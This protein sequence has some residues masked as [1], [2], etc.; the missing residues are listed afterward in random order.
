MDL[1]ITL[2]LCG[3][4][5]TGRG[6]DQALPH[7]VNP[8]LHEPFVKD[9]RAY[10][11]L[12][13]QKFGK[14]GIPVTYD[15]IWGDA[16]QVLGQVN[17]AVRI[18]NL[19]TAVTNSDEW[20]RAKGIHYRM[21]PRNVAC[22]TA[23]GIDVCVLA[24]NHVLDWGESGLRETLATIAGVGMK[25]AG[26]GLD[27][28]SAVAPA[29]VG[30]PHGAR[31]L[32]F[33][34]AMP[35]SGVPRGWSAGEQRPG[36]HFLADLSDRSAERIAELIRT[37]ARE[38]DI[39]VFSIHW[40]ENWGYANADEQ[41]RFARR[42]IDDAGVD[43]VYGHSSHHVMGFEIYKQR[44]I[45]YGCGDFL[46]DYEGIGGH[47]GYRPDLTLMYFPTFDAATGELRRLRMAPMQ[48]RHFRVNHACRQDA[49]WLRDRLNRECKRFGA[50]VELDEG[51]MLSVSSAQ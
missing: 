43:V 23:A 45:F 50:H 3:D 48:V 19:E 24:N 18:I 35:D 46:N 25:T 39:V 7:S 10:L 34:C 8:S 47:E 44:P 42:L 40:G 14:V 31:V 30:A 37:H 15:H 2:F 5:M 17:P 29:V 21:H 6:I 26:A 36:V 1:L 27:H 49:E 9:A 32:V 41:V 22:L 33:A 38:R 28:D 12:A 51:G 16:L 11:A 13:E 4:V 20:D